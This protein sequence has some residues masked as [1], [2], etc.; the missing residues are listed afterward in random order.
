MCPLAIGGSLLVEM[1]S[2]I[3]CPFCYL[4]LRRLQ[5]AIDS[6][7]LG[8]QV[9]LRYRSF[10][11]APHSPPRRAESVAE[12]LSKKYGMPLDQAI[13]M[14]D[15][16][17]EQGGSL[18]IDFHFER[19]VLVNTFD[20]HRLIHLAAE[21]DLATA[22]KERLLHAYFT[23]GEVVSDPETLVRLATDI[24]LDPEETAEM[25][26]GNRFVEA[27]RADEAA[28]GELGITGVPFVLVDG[29][30]AVPGA[31]P[32]GHFERALRRAADLAARS[33]P[34]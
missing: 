9:E 15:G 3:A 10:E 17:R 4:G 33:E 21:H 26:A 28:A 24:G 27:V 8:A 18:G 34:S 5:A 25:L 19:V 31:Q 22:M 11:L 16:L 2:D 30:V 12:H 7:G 20:A 1:W 32:V 23:D 14:N 29:A 6:T 13:G